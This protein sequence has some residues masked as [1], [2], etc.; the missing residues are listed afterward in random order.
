MLVSANA[1]GSMCSAVD[2]ADGLPTVMITCSEGSDLTYMTDML[3]ELT[4]EHDSCISLDFTRVSDLQ[5][6]ALESL[7][8]VANVLGERSQ[9]LHLKEPGDNVCRML[10]RLLLSDAFCTGENRCSSG[11]SPSCSMTCTRWRMDF[12]ALAPD[13][14]NGRHAR[15]RVD[16]LAEQMG[17]SQEFRSEVQIAVGEAF[18]N[19][20][21]Y[22][23]T[24]SSSKVY[25][26]CLAT[27]HKLCVTVTDNGSGFELSSVPQCSPDNFCEHGR[28]IRCIEALMDDVDYNFDSGTTL[29]MIK[30]PK[31]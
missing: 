25:I 12:F 23:C 9:K 30:H 29:R 8:D 14:S 28:G 27:P 22:G 1:V 5:H 31:N 15:K 21:E 18:A 11:C 24:D 2:F 4:D 26:S 10:D 20:A 7:T 6:V 13:F 19:A 3:I 17:F 16:K